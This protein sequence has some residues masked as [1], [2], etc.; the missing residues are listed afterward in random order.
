M[1]LYLVRHGQSEG[2]VLGKAGLDPIMTETGVRQIDLAGKRLKEEGITHFYCSPLYRALA[3]VDIFRRHLPLNPII[4]PLF[5]EIWGTDWKA[6]TA[7]TLL[8]SFPW[9]ELPESMF[10]GRWWPKEA[11]NQLQI[12]RRVQDALDLI[13]QNHR[14]SA[15]KVCLVS[16]A[17]MGN[18]ML[19]ILLGMDLDSQIIFAQR[20]GAFSRMEFSQHDGFLLNYVN[21]VT[22]LSPD[23]WT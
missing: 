14:T 2:N 21:D 11:E 6:R 18:A 12:C 8:E 22:H 9:A 10:N 15:D 19:H 1:I 4:S 23:L 5:C 7:E 13:F 20:N 17:A 16:H 3:T